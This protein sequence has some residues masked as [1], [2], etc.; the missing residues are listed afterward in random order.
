MARVVVDA[1]LA[2]KWVLPESD[3]PQALTLYRTW[4]EQRQELLAPPLIQYEASN[5]IWKACRRG[6]LSWQMGRRVLQTFS[7]IR[8]TFHNPPELLEEAW[9]MAR[10]YRLPTTYDGAYLALA[11]LQGCELWTGDT[12]L[13]NTLARRL[14]WVRGLASA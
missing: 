4:I 3:S 5:A 12:R 2:A 9:D 13:L 8:F 6:D 10:A 1:S 11:K 7:R 14:P